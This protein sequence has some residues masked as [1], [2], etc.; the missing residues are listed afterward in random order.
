M[1]FHGSEYVRQLLT[2]YFRMCAMIK[3]EKFEMKDEVGM[4]VQQTRVA[5]RDNHHTGTSLCLPFS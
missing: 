5:R 4:A 3:D 2:P 1:S